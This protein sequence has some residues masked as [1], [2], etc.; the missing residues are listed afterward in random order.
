[1]EVPE[2]ILVVWIPPSGGA[3]ER[4]MESVESRVRADV[5]ALNGCDLEAV[6]ARPRRSSGDDA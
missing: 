6:V 1:M 5:E 2:S 4:Q 3:E